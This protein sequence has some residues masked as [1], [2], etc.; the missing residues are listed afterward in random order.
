MSGKPAQEGSLRVQVEAVKQKGSK[1]GEVR[2][3]LEG[4]GCPLVSF[5]IQ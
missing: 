1:E 5:D 3:R 4:W 2:S